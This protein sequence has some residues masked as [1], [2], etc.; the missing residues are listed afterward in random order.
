MLKDAI[1]SQCRWAAFG[2]GFPTIVVVD[3]AGKIAYRTDIQPENREQ[4]MKEMGELAKSL[5]IPWPPK[6]DAPREEMEA[7]MNKLMVANI[8]REIDR[9]LD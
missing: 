8:S 5:E 3:E 2:S 9:V 7:M 4:F 6:N 1:G